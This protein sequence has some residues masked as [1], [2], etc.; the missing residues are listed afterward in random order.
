MRFPG[1][2]LPGCVALL[3][4]SAQCGNRPAQEED[5]AGS[6]LDADVTAADARAA[7][8]AENASA[9]AAAALA[10][11]REN[12]PAESP[13]EIGRV[14]CIRPEA[15]VPEPA[16]PTLEDGVEYWGYLRECIDGRPAV[17]TIEVVRDFWGAEAV[18]EAAK[19]GVMLEPDVDPVVHWR[20]FTPLRVVQVSVKPDADIRC[21]DIQCSSRGRVSL[22]ALPWNQLHRFRLQNGMIVH[23]ELPYFP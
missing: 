8:S 20:R 17:V 1:V 9:A 11:P 3:L 12:A 5:A 6:S 10:A 21:E 23:L 13:S 4:I 18:R 22:D 7:S 16:L 14:G 19:D 15:D 2:A